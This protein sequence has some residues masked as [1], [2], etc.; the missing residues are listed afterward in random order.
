MTGQPVAAEIRT[1][2]DENVRRLTRG[3]DSSSR[4]RIEPERRV[5]GVA[6]SRSDERSASPQRQ[7]ARLAINR[8]GL[9][10]KER[11]AGGHEDLQITARGAPA[12]IELIELDLLG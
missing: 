10:Q 1:P 12:G 6:V 4:P 9:L 5:V 2:F 11:S 8:N 3:I 7:L